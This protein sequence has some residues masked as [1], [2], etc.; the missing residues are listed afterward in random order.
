MAWALSAITYAYM[1]DAEEAER[2]IN[3][4]KKLSPLDPHAFFFDPPSSSIHLLKRDYESAVGRARGHPDEPVVFRCVKPYL[5]ALGHAGRLQEASVVRRRLLAIEPDLL[6]N[7]FWRPRRSNGPATVSI[8]PKGFVV[9]AF[10]RT[11]RTS[12]RSWS[13]RCHTWRPEGLGWPERMGRSPL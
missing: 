9:P 4:Y 12:R 2:R 1:G 8:L 6:S 10:R 13:P 5:A 11:T 7:G 3:R